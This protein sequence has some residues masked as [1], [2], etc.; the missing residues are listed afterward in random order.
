MRGVELTIEEREEISR[1]IRA[2]ESGREIGRVAGGNLTPRRWHNGR[3][4]TMA[5]TTQLL[6]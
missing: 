4:T 5:S 2:G 1:G 3:V 6:P